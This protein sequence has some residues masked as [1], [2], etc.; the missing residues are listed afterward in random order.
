M[1]S[2][3]HLANVAKLVYITLQYNILIGQYGFRDGSVVVKFVAGTS[4]FFYFFE[5]QILSCKIYRKIIEN[6]CA[7]TLN[8]YIYTKYIHIFGEKQCVYP[9]A[10]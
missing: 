7:Y 3:F 1:K 9:S 8:N 4:V 10:I 6:T 5:V 2:E